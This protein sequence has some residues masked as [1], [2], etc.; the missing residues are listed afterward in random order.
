MK[1]G[2]FTLALLTASVTIGIRSGYAQEAD[3]ANS[4]FKV[5]NPVF[6]SDQE[7]DVYVLTNMRKVQSAVEAY[8]A[9]HEGK[10]PTKIDDALKSYFPMG[11]Q[12]DKTCNA[13]SNPLNPYTNKRAWPI[14][15]K[16]SSLESA[17]AAKPGKLG[18]G[19]LEFSAIANGNDY[20]IRGGGKDGLALSQKLIGKS[21]AHTL[22]LSKDADLLVLASMKTLQ[23]SVELY[24]EDHEGEFPKKLDDSFKIYLPGGN[25]ERKLA[26]KPLFNVITKK[27][28]WPSQGKI[29]SIL[30]ARHSA[31]NAIPPGHLEYNCLPD[32]RH[33]AI[34]GGAASGKALEGISGPK[35]TMVIAKDGDGRGHE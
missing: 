25:P 34:R 14:A 7:R 11:E 20:A 5:I 27:P 4:L 2:P 33:Y 22:V 18:P 29:T 16:I 15:G 13:W 1:I 19:V 21:A 32:G 6:K 12:D 10:Y 24:G 28:D 9:H 17:R 35:S 8:A 30:E 3:I 23:H 26:G 31:P